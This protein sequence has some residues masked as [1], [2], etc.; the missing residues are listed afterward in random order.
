MSTCRKAIALITTLFF[1][2]AITVSIGVGLKYVNE[3]S[4]EVNSE[5]FM[6]Q[7]S[8]IID[9]VLTMLKNS[10]ELESI[11]GEKSQE[12]LFTFL[13]QSSFIPFESSGLKINLEFSSA[14]SRFNP[15]TLADGNSTQ[16]DSPRVQALREYMSENMVDNIYVD[17]LLDSMSGVKE[18][19]SYNTE[20]FNEKPYLFRDYIASSKH[21]DELNSFYM[22]AIQENSLKNINFENLFYFSSDRSTIID[23]NYATADV[24]ELMLGCTKERAKTIAVDR[25]YWNKIE[26]ID[27]QEDEKEMLERFNPSYFEPYIDVRVEI[28]QNNK[29][30]NIRFEYNIKTKKGSNFNYDI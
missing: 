20:I 2:M 19:F 12:A 11:V 18:D 23:L 15:N 4:I 21:L 16:V 26:D 24:W 29:R 10:K 7:T 22:Q 13:S 6:I 30:A 1:I 25:G 8:V 9:D 5:N 14:R 28:L 17:I 3:A 27:L